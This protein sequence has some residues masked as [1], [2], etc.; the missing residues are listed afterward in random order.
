MNKNIALPTISIELSI[1]I[2][3]ISSFAMPTSIRFL[4]QSLIW[5]LCQK[6]KTIFQYR[7]PHLIAAVHTVG[8]VPSYVIPHS[9]G[10][11]SID[12]SVSFL[13]SLQ[14]L[15]LSLAIKCGIYP[16][17]NPWLPS[18]VIQK[19]LPRLCDLHLCLQRS[20][21]NFWLKKYVYKLDFEVILLYVCWCT[22]YFKGT[23][24]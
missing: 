10:F 12:M 7:L 19:S 11:P 14:V 9:H 4:L 2:F 8:H 15:L 18:L 20:S 24:I 17:L 1:C 5:C 6:I 22:Y 21:V 13:F 23:F 3:S 16:R